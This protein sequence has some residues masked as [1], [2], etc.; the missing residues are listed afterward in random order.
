MMNSKKSYK[1]LDSYRIACSDRRIILLKPNS[2]MVVVLAKG[3]LKLPD[4]SMLSL[5]PSRN[6]AFVSFFRIANNV[7]NKIISFSP[8]FGFCFLQVVK[9]S[10]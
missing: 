3:F 9:Q 8:L 6:L 5:L 7:L 4:L 1:N 2:D 10:C